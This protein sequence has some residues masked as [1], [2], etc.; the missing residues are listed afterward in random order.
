MKATEIKKF[1]AKELYIIDLYHDYMKKIDDLDIRKTLMTLIVES[2]IHADMFDEL[3]RQK[4]GAGAKRQLTDDEIETL[5]K[6]GMK[7]EVDAREMYKKALEEPDTTET[8][9]EALNMIISDE[10]RHEKMLKD[11]VRRLYE[12]NIQ[13]G[14]G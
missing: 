7:E 5:L 13:R 10:I 9:K 2:L 6:E 14:R 1:I 4:I 3:L 8:E 12:A 11:L